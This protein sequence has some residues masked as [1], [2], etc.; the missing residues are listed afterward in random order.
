MKERPILF[1]GEMVR[2][3]LAGRKTQTRRVVNFKRL[4]K[5]RHG[6]LFFSETFNSWA[7]D[8]GDANAIELVDCPY[9]AIGDQLWVRECWWHYKTAELEMAAFPGYTVTKLAN[10][11]HGE[12]SKIEG[13]T[14]VDYDIYRKRPSI[15]MPRWASR[16]SLEITNVRLEVLDAISEADAKAEGVEPSGKVELKDGSPC[17]SAAFRELW[18]RINGIDNPAAW[19]RNPHVW[20]VEF[21]RV[22]NQ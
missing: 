5:C 10:G 8:S 6:R 16:I 11:S 17:Y 12:E 2:A 20:V 21:K 15:H 18:T 22:A 9:G 7:I 13:W 1:S 19:E 3:I 14:P 4:T